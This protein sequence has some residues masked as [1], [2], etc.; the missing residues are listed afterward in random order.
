MIR[1]AILLRLA[2]LVFILGVAW[3]FLVHKA[4]AHDPDTGEPNWITDGKYT[5]PGGVS[6]CGPND[7][8]RL[9]P[10]LV[11]ATPRGLILHAYNNELV[12]WN[13]ATPSEDK[14]YWRCHMTEWGLDGSSTKKRRCFFAPVGSQ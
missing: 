2:F 14:Y 5:S 3:G 8:E 13:E 4:H 6:C 12:P 9:D 7:C 10:K 11:E 1:L